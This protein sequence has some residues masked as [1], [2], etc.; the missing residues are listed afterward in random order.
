M[1]ARRGREVTEEMRSR[2][3]NSAGERGATTVEFAVVA[4]VFFMALVSIFG[5]ANLYFTHNALVEATRRGARYAAMHKNDADGIAKVKKVV[6]YGTAAPAAGAQPIA[7]GLS[8]SNAAVEYS[9]DF[10]VM[11]GTA[12]VSVTGYQYNFVAPGISKVITMPAYRTT[13]RGE[14]AGFCTDSSKNT[15]PCP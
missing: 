3:S 6:V 12:S 5:G 14:S 9:A 2:Q 13:M 1:K 8:E 11:Q 15:I 7:S 4:S 10:G